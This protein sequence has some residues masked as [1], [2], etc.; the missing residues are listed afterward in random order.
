M[1]A[2]ARTI[3]HCGISH[4]LGG[5]NTAESECWLWNMCHGQLF[6]KGC[7]VFSH[8][9]STGAQPSVSESKLDAPNSPKDSY[10]GRSDWW[11]W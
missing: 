11:F 4:S 8:L 3:T 9:A 1:N 5:R 7:D 10:P 6:E 2:A